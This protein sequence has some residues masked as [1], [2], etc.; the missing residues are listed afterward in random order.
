M[1]ISPFVLLAANAAGVGGCFSL[2]R[3]NFSRETGCGEGRGLQNPLSLFPGKKRKRL[4]MV[5]REKG[6]AA[7]FQAPPEMPFPAFY[8]GYWGAESR[9]WTTQ[10]CMAGSEIGGGSGDALCFSFAAAVRWLREIGGRG[11]ARC[12]CFCFAAVVVSKERH[13]AL[14]NCRGAAAKRERR[15]IRAGPHLHSSATSSVRQQKRR[16]EHPGETRTFI[17]VKSGY[18]RQRP[19]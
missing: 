4:L 7:A 11:G 10:P 8:G 2:V 19:R 14:S 13:Q 18:R 6:W 1:V 17:G 15:S 12:P 16:A 3:G 5:S 9:V